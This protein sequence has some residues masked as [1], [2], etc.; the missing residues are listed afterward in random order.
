MS[1]TPS[2]RILI[3]RRP[4]F[5]LVEMIVT[6]GIIGLLLG[7]TFPAL[8]TFQRE[9][10]NV[11][12]LSNLKQLGGILQTYMNQSGGL[13]PMVDFIPAATNNG[14]VG[15]LPQALRGFIDKDDKCWCCPSDTDAQGSLSTGTSYFY[16]PGLLRYSPN[17]QIQVQ[18]ALIPY[19]LD[20]TATDEQIERRQTEMEC[21]IVTAFY[22]QDGRRMPMLLDSVDRHP[23]TRIPRNALFFDGS[24]GM[25]TDTAE[26]L[27]GAEDAQDDFEEDPD[28][29]DSLDSLGLLEPNTMSASS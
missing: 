17:V 6:I 13:P 20:P 9:G 15:G 10:Q 8:R 2:R 26:I 12:C 7:L 11:Q 18:Q 4:G 22:R 25:S 27:E 14:P 23:G 1:R 21:R 24:V 16:M 29:T 28:M 3:D 19:Y 5:T